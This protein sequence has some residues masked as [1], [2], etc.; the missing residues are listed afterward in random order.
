MPTTPQQRLSAAL[1]FI[2]VLLLAAGC[3]SSGGGSGGSGSGG[4]G[5]GGSPSNGSR[6]GVAIVSPKDGAGDVPASAAIEFRT[7][8][9]SGDPQVT[10]ARAGGQ[11]VAGRVQPGGTTWLPDAQLDWGTA[12]TATLTATDAEGRPATATA[13]FTTM[14]KPANLV[15]VSS[16][17]GDGTVVGVG[18]PMIV[19]FGRAI[20]EA[21]RAD[22][23]KRMTVTT[24]P[25]Q[26]GGWRWFSAT[27]VHYRPKQYWQPGTALDMR[28]RTGG[29]PVGDGW[30]LRTDLT[31]DARVGTALVMTVNNATKQMVV[32]ENGRA[33]R[34]IPVSLGRPSMPSSSGTL[35]VMERL[36]KTV[37]DTRTDPN[38]ANRYRVD[39]EYAQRLT[40]G[41]EFIH[42]APWSVADQGRRNVSHGCINMS[43]A[44]AQWLFTKTHV[45][46]PVVVKGTERQVAWGNG[47]TDWNMGFDQYA[48]G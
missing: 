26:E 38:P 41:G 31:V 35:L 17:V 34:T 48:S 28:L 24:T 5:S 40:Y 16:F 7:D 42:A 6:A 2:V 12:Y 3:T 15:R 47:W 37:F 21:Q 1:G 43:T 39:I 29:L 27:E 8:G 20:P 32:T 14:D 22:V 46:D 13:T 36:R 10:L 44:N 4:S 33:L 18:M 9:A 19:Q 25:P 23:V 45:G 30:Y 11:P